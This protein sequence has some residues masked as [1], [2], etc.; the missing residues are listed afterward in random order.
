MGA[1]WGP[2]LLAPVVPIG[3]YRFQY[4]QPK[5]VGSKGKTPGSQRIPG[6]YCGGW[7][8]RTPEGLHPT[9]FPSVR[10]RP[11]GESSRHP[12]RTAV[13]RRPRATDMEYIGHRA[14]GP[15]ALGGVSH[16]ARGARDRLR[17][18]GAAGGADPHGC[19]APETPA[20][21]GGARPPRHR[22]HSWPAPR[23]ASSSESPRTGR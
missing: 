19:S 21:L 12:A 9:R 22:V 17:T 16:A 1:H 11:L 23:A 15:A 3:I 13:E 8:I 18:P 4:P 7:G 20:A 14:S 2:L 6:T 10:H 5:T